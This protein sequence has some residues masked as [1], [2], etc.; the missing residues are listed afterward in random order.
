MYAS[1]AATK[2]FNDDPYND[3]SPNLSRVRQR[4][5]KKDEFVWNMWKPN[6]AVERD[7]R[8]AKIT[9]FLAVDENNKPR[10]VEEKAVVVIFGEYKWKGT[11][12]AITQED[13]ETWMEDRQVRNA[14]WSSMAE[15]QRRGGL[16]S[17]KEKRKALDRKNA[18]LDKDAPVLLPNSEAWR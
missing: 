12:Y 14:A 10:Q 1:F 6:L 7:K 5:L 18:K 17:E 3:Y 4:G 15:V 13:D 2:E 9:E 8:R 11:W 16:V